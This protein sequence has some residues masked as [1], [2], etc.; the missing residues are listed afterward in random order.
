MGLLVA[1]EWWARQQPTVSKT[2]SL[3]NFVVITLFKLQSQSCSLL[4]KQL[5]RLSCN[6]NSAN[7]VS[8]MQQRAML[9][10]YL[11][12]IFNLWFLHL[13]KILKSFCS[14]T[15]HCKCDNVTRVSVTS[16]TWPCN[17]R[18]CLPWY[19]LNHYRIVRLSRC[20]KM[21][22]HYHQGMQISD[23]SSFACWQ[24]AKLIPV[25][26]ENSEL[27]STYWIALP[28]IYTVFNLSYQDEELAQLHMRPF[29]Y[30]NNRVAKRRFLTVVIQIFRT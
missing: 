7:S 10:T 15:L 5:T 18:Y 6:L 12:S 9:S 19:V 23:V 22:K 25:N 20:M 8:N 3:P 14:Y 2:E 13:L 28:L 26:K 24:I 29:K 16:P 17:V 27:P 11:F 21:Q 30:Y 1:Y 4:L